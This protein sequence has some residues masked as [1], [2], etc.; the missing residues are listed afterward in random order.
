MAQLDRLIKH[1]SSTFA[2]PVR[3]ARWC[4]DQSAVVRK[5]SEFQHNRRV[6]G[7]RLGLVL[8]G[9]GMRGAYSIG[10]LSVLQDEELQTA[11][12][13]VVGSSAG[14]VN[15]AYF[16]ASQCQDSIR[17]YVEELS[18]KRFINLFRPRKILEIDFLIDEMLRNDVD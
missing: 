4:L 1:M 2:E 12:D 7:T 5:L 14:A 16:L 10:A 15:G 13:V 6:A 8:Q 17:A 11:F 9:G 3:S 18:N